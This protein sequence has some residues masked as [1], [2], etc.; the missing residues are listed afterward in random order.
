MQQCLK[1]VFNAEEKNIDFLEGNAATKE[2]I[3]N[4]ISSLMKKAN[5]NDAIVFFFSGYAGKFGTEDGDEGILCPVNVSEAGGILDRLLLQL[6]DK[7]SK[8]CRNNIVCRT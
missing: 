5:R 7:V 6:F 8:S 2:G 3:I 4:A 1:E